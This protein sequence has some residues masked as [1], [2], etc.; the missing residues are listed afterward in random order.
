[1]ISRVGLWIGYGLL[2][3]VMVGAIAWHYLTQSPF[4]TAGLSDERLLIGLI[5]VAAGL[6]VVRGVF[7]ASLSQRKKRGQH[8]DEKP[9]P[10]SLVVYLTWGLMLVVSVVGLTSTQAL[11]DFTGFF[12]VL[13]VMVMF[14]IGLAVGLPM[15]IVERRRKRTAVGVENARVA[16]TD[17]SD[18]IAPTSKSASMSTST[19]IVGALLLTVG[20]VAL[21][22]IP[23]FMT[24]GDKGDAGLI[25]FVMGIP[26][27]LL[28][29]AI[30]IVAGIVT[31]V[32]KGSASSQ[33]RPRPEESEKEVKR[34]PLGD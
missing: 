16:S 19:A 34:L 31:L 32:S 27:G 30:F 24:G 25:Y 11:G 22:A 15:I 13:I 17:Q 18:S 9:M 5:V 10:I 20:I 4:A 7:N 23:M 2:A 21:F 8:V 14:F 28:F 26:L 1:M 33:S 12:D 29:G 6:H 3:L